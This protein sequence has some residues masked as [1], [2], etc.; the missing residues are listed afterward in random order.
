MTSTSSTDGTMGDRRPDVGSRPAEQGPDEPFERRLDAKLLC[1]VVATGLTTF[2]GIVGETAMNV[3]FPELMR[4]FGVGTST[5]QWITTGYLLTIACVIALSSFL[6]RRFRTRALFCSGVAVF[7]VGVVAGI[8]APSFPILLAGRVL[9]GMGL[10]VALPLM[11]NIIM[12]Q[13][14]YR[15][16]GLLMGIGTLVIAVSPAVG[17]FLGGLIQSTL[18]WRFIFVAQTPVL[19]AALLLGTHGIRQASPTERL[20]FDVPGYLLLVVCFVTLI[21]GVSAAGESGWLSGRVLLLLAVALVAAGAFLVRERRC[22]HPVIRTSV[23]R[24]PAFTAGMCSILIIQFITLSLGYLIPNYAQLARGADAFLAGCLLV[25]G[26]FLGAVLAPIS[27]GIADRVGFAR[28]IF[29]GNLLVVAGGACFFALGAHVPVAALMGLFAVF[30]AG[31]GLSV[32]NTLTNSLRQLPEEL[33][34]DGNAAVNTLQQLSGALGTGVTTTIVAGAQALRPGDLAAGTV[35]GALG[36][37][38]VLAVL[39]A[40]V[41]VCSLTSFVLS[42][43]AKRRVAAAS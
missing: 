29:A 23:F 15:K 9:Q 36:V 28:P 39:A 13:A 16:M 8:F 21:L 5:V 20:D 38:G 42:R 27:G 17:P 33:S 34:T 6:K 30:A 25:P 40:C 19:V 3:T 4:E 43:R 11:Y 22:D 35:A 41:L 24:V 26:A 10:G 12:E 31:Q 2:A 14:P 18:G 37:Y 7:A 32:G 1:A